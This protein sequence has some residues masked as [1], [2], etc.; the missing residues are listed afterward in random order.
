LALRLERSSAIV[1]DPTSQWVDMT[2]A[3]PKG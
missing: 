2:K 1:V 3:G